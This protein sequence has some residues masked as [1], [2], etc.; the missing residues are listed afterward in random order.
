[1]LTIA[2][3]E[4][5]LSTTTQ[6]R[7]DRPQRRQPPSERGRAFAS[8]EVD[9]ATTTGTHQRRLPTTTQNGPD[10]PQKRRPL[11]PGPTNEERRS[12]AATS[13]PL[14][15][16]SIDNDHPSTATFDRQR[17]PRYH[18][19]RSTA[20][21]P[22]PPRSIDNGHHRRPRTST[23]ADHH[24]PQATAHQWREQLRGQ[25]ERS[26]ARTPT[27]AHNHYTRTATSTPPTHSNFPSSIP[28]PSINPSS[29]LIPLPS[30]H[31]SSLLHSCSVPLSPIHPSLYPPSLP[32]STFPPSVHLPSLC[33]PSLPLS[34]FTPSVYLPSLCLPSLSPSPFPPSPFPPSLLPPCLPPCLPP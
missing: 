26:P 4:Q 23:S 6:N 31:P 30:F 3:H 17:P 15:P 8:S 1:M 22:L 27:T 7:P 32:L 25:A 21:T 5:R 28:L 19:A 20:A 12:P 11:T 13:T 2:T 29:F 16:R 34:T 18:H 33:L 14:P 24:P 9:P 10:R